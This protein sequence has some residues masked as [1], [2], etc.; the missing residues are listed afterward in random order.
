[1]AAEAV[2]LEDRSAAREALDVEL[3]QSAAVC[4]DHPEGA[5]CVGGDVA[6]EDDLV[7]LWRPVAVVAALDQRPGRG[8]PMEVGAVGPDDEEADA[9]A[10]LVGAKEDEA[11]AVGGVGANLVVSAERVRGQASE[12][13]PVGGRE[14]VDAVAGGVGVVPALTG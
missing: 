8:D 13:A 5:A 9:V 1:M 11:L 7:A 10:V 6:R 3:A 14:R 2:G 4:V 12:A